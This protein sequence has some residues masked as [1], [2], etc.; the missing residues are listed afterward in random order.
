MLSND[1]KKQLYNTYLGRDP[2]D[3]NPISEIDFYRA[4]GG[5]VVDI[6]NRQQQNIRDLQSRVTQLEKVVTD[7]QKLLE[8]QSKELTEAG[9]LK[10]TLEKQ[11]E[12]L[13][14]KIDELSTGD[15]KPSI[16]GYSLGELLSAAFQ[17]LFKIR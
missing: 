6:R 7:A 10:G 8:K 4:A 11:V 16:D 2:E 13:N 9:A 15:Q 12:A 17:K 3:Y 5:E 14:K 1:Q